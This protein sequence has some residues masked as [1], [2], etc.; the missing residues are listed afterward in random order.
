MFKREAR[1]QAE[2]LGHER[3]I[4]TPAPHLVILCQGV[5]IIECLQ[6]QPVI[7]KLHGWMLIQDLADAIEINKVDWKQAGKPR[8]HLPS[9]E[10]NDR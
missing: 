10:E 6:L 8:P 7:I 1:I 5:N 3:R 2:E 4:R 9:N